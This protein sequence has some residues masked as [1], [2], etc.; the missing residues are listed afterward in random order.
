M[1][2][3]IIQLI[4]GFLGSAGFALVFN[5]RLKNLLSPSLNGLFTT[6]IFL[7]MF[8]FY[9]NYFI[10]CF[11]A[12]A[13]SALFGEVLARIKKT[14]ASVFFIPGVVSLIP[15]GALFYTMSYAVKK[16]WINCKMYG[17]LTMEY[18]LGIACGISIAWA[19]W[20]MVQKMITNMVKGSKTEI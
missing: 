7:L 1:N 2:Q 15:G 20:Y 3:D 18:A 13:F 4:T 14:P 12:S 16:D 19:L 5:V 6:G 9:S 10:A 11:V 17:F 8:R